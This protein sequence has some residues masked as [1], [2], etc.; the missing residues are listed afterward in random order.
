MKNLNLSNKPLKRCDLIHTPKK[1][2]VDWFIRKRNTI[3]FLKS[4]VFL[5][6]K[7]YKLRSMLLEYLDKQRLQCKGSICVEYY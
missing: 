2:F 1:V 6:Q 3:T 4:K 7:I 5:E